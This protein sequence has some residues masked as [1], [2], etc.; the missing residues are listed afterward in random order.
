MKLRKGKAEIGMSEE[1]RYIQKRIWKA[2]LQSILFYLCRIFPVRKKKIVFCCI[3]GTT[4]YTCNP[5]YIAEELIRRNEGYELVWLVNDTKKTFPKEIKV[6][7][8]TLP[9]RAYQLSTASGSTTAESSW[10]PGNAG[11][12]FI[13]R[14]GMRSWG[15]S[16]PAWTGGHPFPGL[17]I[18]SASMIRT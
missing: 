11:G 12:R 18:W 14:P 17:L 8:N 5:K 4:G 15:S 16:P 6:V 1:E 13:Y 7:R 10:R 2:R 3:E 9:N